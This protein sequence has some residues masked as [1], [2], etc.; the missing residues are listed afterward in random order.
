ME[1][2]APSVASGLSTHPPCRRSRARLAS[3]ATRL[4]HTP[5]DVDDSFD[6]DGCAGLAPLSSP[7]GGTCRRVRVPFPPR[8]PSRGSPSPRGIARSPLALA[9]RRTSP[10]S[11]PAAVSWTTATRASPAPRQARSP[12]S[13]SPPRTTSTFSV[14]LRVRLV[15][16]S[17]P[18]PTPPPRTLP[19]SPPSSPAPRS[20]GRPRWTSSRGRSRAKTRTTAPKNRRAESRPGRVVVGF[21]RRRRRG[22]AT[23]PSARTP[24]AASASPRVLRHLRF[25]THPRSC[26]SR[27]VRPLAPSL[28]SW[29]VRR[30]GSS[31]KAAGGGSSTARRGHHPTDARR[32]WRTLSVSSRASRRATRSRFATRRVRRRRRPRRRRSRRAPRRWH[33]RR[34]RG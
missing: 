14:R 19:P 30:R 31:A 33:R 18:T 10:A 8:V 9:A 17:R 24:R 22:I 28:T 23:S 29:C 12:A 27:G 2:L 1:R 34:P 4:V 21:R 7:F 32:R 6:R 5:R 13:P 16:G 3:A 25:Q 15:A 11:A 26:Q 20:S